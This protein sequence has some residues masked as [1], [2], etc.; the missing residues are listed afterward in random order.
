[1]VSAESTVSVCVAMVASKSLLCAPDNDLNTSCLF[2]LIPYGTTLSSQTFNL[3]WCNIHEWLRSST[4]YRHGDIT[5]VTTNGPMYIGQS[6]LLNPGFTDSFL[7]YTRSPTS[8]SR[9]RDWHHSKTSVALV[10]LWGSCRLQHMPHRA[11]L[12]AVWYSQ[13]VLL[14]APCW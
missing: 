5:L 3:S 4:W 14:V 8:N 13:H 10:P 6:F 1:M 2:L 12:S 11:A 7:R 9:I